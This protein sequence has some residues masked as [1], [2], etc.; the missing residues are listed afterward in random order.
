MAELAKISPVPLMLDEAIT[1]EEDLDRTIETGCAKAV[2]FKLMKAGSL[3]HLEKL[4]EKALDAG[5]KVI[6]GNGVATDIGCAHE[7]QAAARTGL[8]NHAGEMNGF[9]K[10][11]EHLLQPVL[12][13]EKGNLIVPPDPLSV[14]WELVE[15]FAQDVMSWGEIKTPG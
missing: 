3:T 12:Q 5:L 14:R 8:T 1:G 11:T 7:A 13:A 9:L 15:R 10:T 6:L 4:I 2:K